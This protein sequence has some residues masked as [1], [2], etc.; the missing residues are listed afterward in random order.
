MSMAYPKPID[1]SIA[2]SDWGSISESLRD[3]WPS[4]CDAAR[5]YLAYF[6]THA[7][8][9]NR[10]R[11]YVRPDTGELIVFVCSKPPRLHRGLVGRI[12]IP[13]LEVKYFELPGSSD[14]DFEPAHDALML[15][16]VCAIKNACEPDVSP[17][18]VTVVDY[19]DYET[20]RLLSDINA[21]T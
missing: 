2:G 12:T 11:V 19:D 3:I 8:N 6:P 4:I 5:A 15:Q 1:A 9:A 18:P 17:L 20:E 10:L 7:A 16:T 14:N 13:Q 21:T